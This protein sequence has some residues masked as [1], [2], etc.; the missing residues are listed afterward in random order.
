MNSLSLKRL[1]AVLIFFSVS[2]S[3]CEAVP[4]DSSPVMRNHKSAAHKGPLKKKSAKIKEP[5][6]VSKSK[7]KQEAKNGKIEKDYTNLVKA[8]KKHSIQIQNPTVRAR[9]KQNIKDSNA[10]IRAKQKNNIS[11]NRKTGRKYR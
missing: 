1:L 7:K 3:V 9:M 4:F 2:L 8:N 6:A 11:R 5:K 10:N